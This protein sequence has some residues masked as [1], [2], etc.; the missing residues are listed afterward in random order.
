MK[1]V[2]MDDANVKVFLE[3]TDL[4]LWHEKGVRKKTGVAH[5]THPL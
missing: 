4:A 3:R 2:I 1:A 5:D